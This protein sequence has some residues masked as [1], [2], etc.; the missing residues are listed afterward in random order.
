MRMGFGGLIKAAVS[1]RLYPNL[2]KL[3]DHIASGSSPLAHLGRLSPIHPWLVD[4]ANDGAQ[5]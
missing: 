2:R 4:Q 5:A 3:E 1:N